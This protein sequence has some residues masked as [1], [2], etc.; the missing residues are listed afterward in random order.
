MDNKAYQRGIQGEEEF[1]DEE[2]KGKIEEIKQ[3]SPDML[4][5][6]FTLELAVHPLALESQ[7]LKIEEND[8]TWEQKSPFLYQFNVTKS[9]PL[10]DVDFGEDE[11]NIESDV[12]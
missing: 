5:L 6:L 4:E 11:D 1:D 10:P 12:T 3:L 8:F 9:V 2:S 7:L